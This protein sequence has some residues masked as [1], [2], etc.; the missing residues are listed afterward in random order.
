MIR[1]EYGLTTFR[2]FLEELARL[3]RLELINDT[4]N[5][6][7]TL[8]EGYLKVI[9]L[10][11]GMEAMVYHF[12]LKHDLLLERK[13]DNADIYSLCFDELV[14][15]QGFSMQIEKE[16]LSFEKN[17]RSS[18]YLT[19]LPL[20]LSYFLKKDSVARGVR[21]LLTQEWMRRYLNMEPENDVLKK[22][23]EM[24]T[25][26]VLSKKIDVESK[27][28]IREILEQHG[29]PTLPLFYK[30]RTLKLIEN[31][32]QWLCHEM[33]DMP[34][35]SDI[36]RDD[37]E[38]IMKVESML[39]GDLSVPPPT[40]AEMSKVVAISE[41]KLKKLFKEV[42]SLPPYEYYQKQR[43]GKAK[44]MLLTGNYSIKD[45]GYAIGYTNM[46]NFTLAFKK[47]FKRLPSELLN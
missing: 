5:L 40:I 45:V 33:K 12:S 2:S 38:R 20:G 1:F 42:Y 3:L 27:E 19:S 32:F 11:D 17:E 10:P 23:I 4:L 22:Y 21:V 6:P 31:F 18:M 29:Q 44:L 37:I 16:Q 35:S 28:I 25:A 34:I 39:V 13:K 8:G 26:G 14:D 46:S 36:S 24:K 41:S 7:E 30:T 9:E 15:I 43:L 47:E